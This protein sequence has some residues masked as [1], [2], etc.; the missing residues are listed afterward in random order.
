MHQ[1]VGPLIIIIIYLALSIVWNKWVIAR[2]HKNGVTIQATN[3]ALSNGSRS[4]FLAYKYT[5]DGKEYGRRQRIT[6]DTYKLFEVAEQPVE[7][8][9]IA[10]K[11]A[12]S[13]LLDYMT[14]LEARDVIVYLV[15]F[16]VGLVVAIFSAT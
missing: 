10:N 1:F 16:S 4:H 13:R 15:I 6:K 11:P 3:L 2:L 14:T 12:T 5:V 7:A 9:Y 8:T